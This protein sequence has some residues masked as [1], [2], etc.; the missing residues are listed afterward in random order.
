MSKFYDWDAIYAD[1]TISART[2]SM[3]DTRYF[4]KKGSETVEV[5]FLILPSARGHGLGDLSNEALVSLYNYARQR[6][7]DVQNSRLDETEQ[8]LKELGVIK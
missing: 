4:L 6:W 8:R 2:V 7:I 5:W 3:F 1:H